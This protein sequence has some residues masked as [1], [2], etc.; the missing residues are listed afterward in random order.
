MPIDNSINNRTFEELFNNPISFEIPFFQRAYSWERQQWKQ[1]ID[2][3]WE[4][5]LPDAI[6][7]IKIDNTGDKI[8]EKLEKQLLEHEHYFGAIV[9]LEKANSDP[10]LKSFV[11]IDGQ[12]RITT[13][14]L[15]IALSSKIL[16]EKNDS[17]ENAQK[18]IDI[19][20][21]YIKNNIESKGDDYRKLKV[22]SNKGDRLPTYLKIFG[23]NPESPSLP[24][25][26]QLYVQGKNQIDV[27][28][29]YAYKK[30]KDYNATLLIIF[31]QAILKSLKIVWIPLDEKKDNPQAIFEGLNDKGMPLSAIELLCSYLFKPLIDDVTKQHESIHN[32]KWLKSIK[33]VGGENEYEFYLRNLFSINKPKMIGKGRKLYANFKNTNKKLS[34]QTAFD[35]IN[36]I[37]DNIDLFNQIVKPQDPSCKHSNKEINSILIK[38][39]RTSMYSSIPFVLSILREQKAGNLN[40]ANTTAI[41]NSLLVL[42]ARR[43]VCELKT[44]K[45]D[46]FFPSLLSKIINEPDKAKAFKDQVLKEDLWVS[47]QEFKDACVNK[48]IYK[49]TEL[50][51]VRLVLQE[52]DKKMQS[53]GQLPDYSSINTIE[54]VMPQTLDD[55]WKSYLGVEASDLNLERIKNSIGNLCLISRSANSFVGQNPFEKKKN[56]Y[57]DVSALTRD[58]KSR[59]V[60]WNMEQIK[61][62]SN[63]LADKALGIWSWE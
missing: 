32:D 18:Q 5:I 29:N 11:V 57:T 40:D 52:I 28:W 21:G 37:A 33:K 58:L 10:A 17:S 39:E 47:D 1:L 35:T 16:K 53:H 62:R 9:V 27:F 45:Y 42:L 55:E 2:D 14:Y 36:E 12:Q 19:L 7:Q 3:V 46:V 48:S 51:F 34:K 44:T 22:Y 61:R 4:Q 26:Q 56:S 20:D 59:T 41:L 60:K 24:I 6:E 43:K 25:D 23:E 54:H 30:L 13:I 8:M 50:E 38:I 63:D 49:Q 31:S 15:L